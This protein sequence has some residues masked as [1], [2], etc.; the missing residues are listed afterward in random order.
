MRQGGAIVLDRDVKVRDIQAD[1]CV[2]FDAVVAELLSCH[3]LSEL[4]LTRSVEHCNKRSFLDLPSS[5]E[6]LTSKLYS[7]R[8]NIHM[9]N[10]PQV[11]Q[12]AVPSDRAQTG[13]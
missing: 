10:I 8:S 12:V 5:K 9:Q 3:A 2:N 13:S 11:P 4:P 7:G 6:T 1:S